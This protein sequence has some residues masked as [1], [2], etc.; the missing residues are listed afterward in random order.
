MSIAIVSTACRFPDAASPADLWAN[1]IEG[2][3]SFREIPPQRLDCASYTADTVGEADSITKIRAGLLTNWRFPR[4]RF[5]IPEKTFVATDLT[6]WLALELA[7]DAIAQIGGVERFDRS[8]TA[9]VVANTLTG[10]FSRASLL[11]LR[12]PF[13]A[14]VLDAAGDA[15]RLPPQTLARLQQRFAGLLRE[16]FA[17]PNEDSLAGGL[18]NTIAGRIANHFD[19]HG[20]AYSVDGACASSLVALIDAANLLMLGQADAVVVAAV[21]LSLDPF[22]LVGFSRNG[23]LA[24]DDMRVFDARAAGFWP[25]EGGA[26]AVLMREERAREDDLPALVK[27]RGWGLSTDGAGG[28]TRPS[29][30]G[31]L[32]A[33]RRAYAMAG[34]DPADLAFVEA[35]GTGTA[36][37][38]PIEVRALAMLRGAAHAPLPIGSIKA[39]VGHTKA[40]AGFAGL[41]KAIEAL[42]HGFFPPHVGCTTP[43]PVFA[44]VDGLVQPAL[45]GQSIDGRGPSLAGVS[46]FGF[47]GVN[48]HVV[49]EQAASSAPRVA[50]VRRPRAQDAELFLFSGDDA[51]DLSAAI[52]ALTQRAPMLSMAE[53]IDAAAHA[54][55]T[56]SDGP[57]RAAVVASSGPELADR[58]AQA[59]R[60]LEGGGLGEPA[61]MVFIGRPATPPRIGFLFPGQAA[62]CRPDGGIWRARFPE[63]ADLLAAMP[64]TTGDLTATEV[65]QPII[66]ASSLAALHV[67]ERLGVTAGVACGHSLGEISAL[68]WSGALDRGGAIEFARVRGRI[69]ARHG[70]VGGAMLRVALSAEDAARMLCAFG[71]VTACHNGPTETVMAGEAGA[72]DAAEHHCA[73]SGIDCVRLPVSHAFHSPHM[74]DAAG[75][76]Q[77]AMRDLHLGPAAA[78]VVSTVTGRRLERDEDVR[79]LL[80][81]QLEAPV[82]FDSALT[83]I[84]V[85]AD[86]LIEVGPGHGLTR[87]ASESAPTSMSVDALGASLKP[88]LACLGTLFVAG[89][90]IRADA[91]FGDRLTR[92]FEPASI[93][94]TIESPCGRRAVAAAV[95]L[96]APSL[97]EETET[98]PPAAA[99]PL[100]VVMA[101]I[102]SESGLDVA[103]ICADDRFLDQLHL[104]SLAV[105]R[106]VREA[107]KALNARAPSVPTE[108]ANATCRQLASAL[109]E[110]REFG[111]NAAAKQERIVGV[112]RWVRT[113]AMHWEASQMPP[114]A[115]EPP[116][117]SSATIGPGTDSHPALAPASGLVI[118]IEGLF[119]AQSAARLLALAAEAARSGVAHLALCHSG[120]PI[121]ATARSMAREGHFQSVRVIDRASAGRD[122]PRIDAVLAAE[123]GSY[124]ELRLSADTGVETPIFSP[125]APRTQLS[126]AITPDDVVMVVGGGKGIAAECALRLAARGPAV[127]LVGRSAADDPEVAAILERV[128]RASARCRYLSADVLDPGFADALTPVTAEFGAA[129]VLVYAAGVNDPKRLTDLDDRLVQNTLALKTTGLHAALDALGPRLRYLVTFG[130]IIGRLGLEG[131]AHYALANAMQTG[132]TEAWAAAAPGRSALAIEW[133]LW[134]GVG[135]GERLGTIERLEAQGVDALSVDHALDVFD[136]LMTGHAVGAVTVTSRFGPPP[137]LDL[138]R[139]ELP[140][141]R[142]VDAPR[143]HFPKVELIVETVMGDGR[144]LY[145]SDHA[146]DGRAVMPGVMGLEAMAQV[147]SALMPLAPRVAL[148]DVAFARAVDAS[149]GALR[150]RIA[151]LRADD[152]TTEVA[153]F[154]EDDDFAEAYMRA[155]FANTSDVTPGAVVAPPGRGFA[156]PPLYGPLFFGGARFRR[157]GRFDL[158]TSRHVSARLKRPRAGTRWFGPYEP[159]GRVLWDPGIADA[160]LHALQVAVPHK[161]MV[162]VACERIEIDRTAGPPVRHYAVERSA[163]AHSYVFD[164]MLTDASGR[165]ACQ[166]SNALFRTIDR[167]DMAAVLPAAPLL[168]RPYLERIAREILADD[169]ITI[170]LID[171]PGTSRDGRRRA[172]LEALGLPDQI[173]H[174]GDGR[175]VRTD[176]RGTISIA[177]GGDITLVAAGGTQIGCDLESMASIAYGE[178]DEICR[179]MAAEVCRKLGR[180]VDARALPRIAPGVATVIEDMRLVLVE[181]VTSS[182]P[183]AVAFGRASDMAPQLSPSPLSVGEAIP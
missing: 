48:A 110:L 177:H 154:T 149:G 76:L 61:D 101:A 31:Q 8:R 19:L 147:A 32:L 146:I 105:A 103:S 43:H 128:R 60:R 183:Y 47:G 35:H 4:S 68:A 84:A 64:E 15:E 90:D 108:Y 10:E 53:L 170:A 13:I 49:L 95:A 22:E 148:S 83:E 75:P 112:R 42:R 166:W 9:V 178:R 161:R 152:A 133:S 114:A 73:A 80:V 36:V 113:Y 141:L 91:L 176:R 28:L 58:L 172:A 117:W 40:A 160:A 109:E 169:T 18:A 78:P 56:R 51:E 87:L 14:D 5:R 102:A 145:L 107:A 86:V 70:S 130:S 127:I 65:A 139:D 121:A 96:A 27:L 171:D 6:H 1:L 20:G 129:S 165:V 138:G 66:V 79:R 3:R 33:A 29:S 118:F 77:N 135:M 12:L 34:V 55:A 72:V 94:E 174:R 26:C 159:Q 85:D 131:E 150:L 46:S 45:T 179:H 144:D 120:L 158:A 37:G 59:R 155:R 97:V 122:D 182:G 156:A 17:E 106:I 62:P 30:E 173:E 2:R 39:N 63:L 44:Q 164:I 181:L 98:A 126:A 111:G 67:L 167:I 81:K 99:E 140:L 125:V 100:A 119:D 157:L 132:A 92:R 168:A 123:A 115:G 11:R 134:G 124:L 143:L 69:M 93:P 16:P 142:F 82:L 23:A 88:L 104:N 89:L 137:S 52:D 136:G 151:A 163:L 71:L 57:L 21:D 25:G 24:A 162:P 180:R 50:G 175:P 7:A 54:A 38:D 153:L 41:I 116:R 74:R